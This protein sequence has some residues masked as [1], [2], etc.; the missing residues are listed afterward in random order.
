M[1]KKGGG[2]VSRVL[3]IAPPFDLNRKLV[4]KPYVSYYEVK[5]GT[6]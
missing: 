1:F 6:S 3:A 4:L 2:K 5:I